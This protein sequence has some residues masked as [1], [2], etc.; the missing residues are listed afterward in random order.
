MHYQV[1]LSSKN[2]ITLPVDLLKNI[3]AKSGDVL[4]MS[5]TPCGVS[6][7]TLSSVKQAALDHLAI[8]NPYN[9]DPNLLKDFDKESEWSKAAVRRYERFIKQTKSKAWK[10]S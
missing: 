1:K 7:K 8:K 5:V 10:L 4:T 2:Q 9:L 6:V 3:K